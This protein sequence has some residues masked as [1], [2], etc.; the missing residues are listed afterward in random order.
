LA[1]VSL[2]WAVRGAWFYVDMNQAAYKA[3]SDW[4]EVYT[5]LDEQHM[6]LEN[7]EQKRLIESLRIQM[8]ALP[9]PELPLLELF[10]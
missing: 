3:R 6:Q 9:P 4:I 1:F 10:R 8:T 5:F 7:A 2:G